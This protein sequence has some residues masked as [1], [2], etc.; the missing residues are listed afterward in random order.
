MNSDSVILLQIILSRSGWDLSL[1]VLNIVFGSF[2]KV[3]YLAKKQDGATN[4]NPILPGCS[5]SCS[6]IALAPGATAALNTVF[7]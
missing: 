7:P 6:Q 3:A 1:I 4:L 2:N 5:L